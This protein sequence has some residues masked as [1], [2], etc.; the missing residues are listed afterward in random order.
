VSKEL[1][2]SAELSRRRVRL[3]A[4]IERHADLAARATLAYG[5]RPNIVNR[6]KLIKHLSAFETASAFLEAIT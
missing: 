4:L 6:M 1:D 3:K 2:F 5:H